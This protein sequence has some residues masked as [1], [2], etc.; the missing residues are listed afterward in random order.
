MAINAGPL[1]HHAPLRKAGLPQGAKAKVIR[2]VRALGLH[3]FAFVR[4]RRGK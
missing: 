3:H 4:Y 1:F 2:E